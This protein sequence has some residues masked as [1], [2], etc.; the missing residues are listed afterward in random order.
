MN[1]AQKLRS[2]AGVLVSLLI[3][4]CGDPPVPDAHLNSW[5][6]KE[7]WRVGGETTGPHSFDANFGLA[8]LPDGSLVHFDY[9]EERFHVLDASGQPIRS[10]GHKGQGPGELS[11][12]N[13]FAVS[14]TGTIVV[15]DRGNSRLSR[16]GVDGT[17]LGSV[18]VPTVFT[19]GIQWDA[20]FLDDGRLVERYATAADSMGQRVWVDHTRIWSGDLSASEV[21]PVD[22]CTVS[23]RPAGAQATFKIA[24]QADAI[25]GTLILPFSGPWFATTVDPAGYVWG[26]PTSGSREV[27]KVGL[28]NCLIAA[29][30]TLSDSTPLI[31][32]AVLDSARDAIA[33]F[34]KAG[35]GSLPSELILPSYFPPY[36]TLHIDDRHQL[37]VQ[38]FGRTGEQIM[39]VYDSSGASVARVDDFPLNARWPM[40]F[41]DGVVY[42]FEADDTG[43]KYLVAL[44]IVK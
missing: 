44:S 24:P 18:V 11:D 39:E 1:H 14:P 38:R 32:R 8:R 31:P 43:I 15:N 36:F 5:T 33:H 30:I 37:W 13:G 42:G 25:A 26:Q 12:A 17:F 10:F 23:S 21:S 2:A 16:F 9:Q 27:R 28:A 6:L 41:A 4:G 35:G 34:A 19:M 40:V 22:S 20:R 29:A 7:L 3:I